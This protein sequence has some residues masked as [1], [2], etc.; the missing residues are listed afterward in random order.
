MNNFD[1]FL[2]NDY[3]GYA[4][5]ETCFDH[6]LHRSSNKNI[7]PFDN[8]IDNTPS[9]NR[10]QVK[11]KDAPGNPWHYCGR[12]T[13]SSSNQNENNAFLY[14]NLVDNNESVLKADLSKLRSNF[15]VSNSLPFI[16]H[17]YNSN[18]SNTFVFRNPIEL[19]INNNQLTLIGS[20]ATSIVDSDFSKL[21]V[22]QGTMELR[23][24]IY[25]I[26]NG[27]QK[28]NI[29][30]L[31]IGDKIQ[32][33]TQL[34]TIAQNN[35]R[36]MTLAENN[37]LIIAEDNMKLKKFPAANAQIKKLSQNN[38][39]LKTNIENSIKI[40]AENNAKLVALTQTNIKLK[41]IANALSDVKPEVPVKPEI[42]S[43]V[44]STRNLCPKSASSD[45]KYTDIQYII[46][47]ATDNKP[48]PEC[49]KQFDNLAA[50][51]IKQGKG[52]L[53][54][55]AH[56]LPNGLT[57]NQCN[58]SN[59]SNLQT[60]AAVWGPGNIVV[61][62]PSN[63]SN[64]SGLFANKPISNN[65]ASEGPLPSNISPIPVSSNNVRKLC[66]KKLG[67]DWKYTDIQYI[68]GPATGNQAYPECNKDHESLA[69]AHFKKTGKN[70]VFPVRT[71]PNGLTY[72]QCNPSTLSDLKTTASIWGPGNIVATIPSK[73]SKNSGLLASTPISNIL[74]PAT[75][76]KTVLKT[77]V[78]KISKT[79]PKKLSKK[80]SK[81][82]YKIGF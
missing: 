64:S 63:C 42:K 13:I 27:S 56:A 43:E 9:T 16:F 17:F 52:N 29:H 32:M 38:S 54:F 68:V 47:P 31:I 55:P 19:S 76:A 6:P 37:A 41:E 73:C 46:G 22:Q 45:W 53:V 49:S 77:A 70:L 26:N 39:Q 23:V 59:L 66:D 78:K 3:S 48:Y 65:P 10:G 69:A 50:A 61:S 62:I 44:S 30:K 2:N 20:R 57:Y 11:D 79:V 40:I 60:T 28:Q 71:L 58:P 82:P 21:K 75:K 24:G 34:K 72:T 1:Q 74:V 4:S 33:N 5:F 8:L 7:E 80:L 67:S 51:N 35:I 36:L 81:K 12:V 15:G 25:D 18:N 14:L